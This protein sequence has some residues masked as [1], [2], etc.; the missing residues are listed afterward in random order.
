MRNARQRG[1]KLEL[2]RV[3]GED[4]GCCGSAIHEKKNHEQENG[5][6]RRKNVFPWY[7]RA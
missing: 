4:V 7:P 3:A 6:R 2:R 1:G 5:E